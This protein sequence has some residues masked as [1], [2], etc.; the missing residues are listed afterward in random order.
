MHFFPLVAQRYVWSTTIFEQNPQNK[1]ESALTYCGYS[2]Q[3]IENVKQV[4]LQIPDRST[5]ETFS[6]TREHYC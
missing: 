2:A 5:R 3:N 6:F 1:T 4:V